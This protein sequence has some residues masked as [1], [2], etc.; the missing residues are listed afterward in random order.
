MCKKSI[1]TRL[2][3][4]RQFEFIKVAGKILFI[5]EIEKPGNSYNWWVLF[6]SILTYNLQTCTELYNWEYQILFF[7]CMFCLGY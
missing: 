4:L 6:L 7:K 2:V 3:D 5:Y 1:D